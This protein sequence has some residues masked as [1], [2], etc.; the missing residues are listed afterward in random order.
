MSNNVEN[1]VAPEATA[2]P[3]AP[4]AEIKKVIDVKNLKMH[5]PLRR[6]LLQRT[7][8]HVKAVDD[9]TFHIAEGE[10]L[11]V[12]GESGCG[13]TTLGR[14][15]MRLY[16]PSSGTID[17][18]GLDITNK[19]YKEMRPIMKDMSM[20]FQ[21]PYSS[22]DP[23]ASAGTIVGEP[24][25][26][27]KI[28]KSKA[29]YQA[30]VSELFTVCG[31]NAD[32]A[33]RFPHEFSGGQRQRLAIARAL[34]SNPSLVVCDEPIAAL[35][36]SMQAQILNLLSEMQERNNK[37][38]YMFISHDLLAVQFISQR[39]AVMYLG[40]IVE[41]APSREIF[42]NTLHPYT[43]ALLSAQ[44]MPDPVAE[45]TRQRI[46]L[47]GDIPTPI[48]PPPGC[49]FH[50]R[51]PRAKKECAEVVPQLRDVGGGHFVS[52]NCV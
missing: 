16:K 6:G 34:A 35:D 18:N 48:N 2:A 52:C 32:M 36:V 42:A 39:I 41:T 46:I 25:L 19:S 26:I 40:R 45:R 20:I 27:H 11:G 28:T 8:G 14:C 22:L 4:A 49:S 29:E 9:V 47:E 17:F 3:A 44:P 24:L 37:M 50:T 21:D 12:V 33:G 7:W 43:E 1:T 15:L 31:L 30:K 5:F 23:R 38:S 13:K 51:C 10:T